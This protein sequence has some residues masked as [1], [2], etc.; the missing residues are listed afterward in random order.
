MNAA[1]ENIIVIVMQSVLILKEVTTALATKVTPV[2]EF[3]VN[4][5][6][7]ST[8]FHLNTDKHFSDI[9]KA[10]L[11]SQIFSIIIRSAHIKLNLNYFGFIKLQAMFETQWSFKSV[12]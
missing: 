8:Y 9:Q 11:M 4:V 3:P 1:Q 2:T 10:Y 6:I 12:K 5:S 7:F